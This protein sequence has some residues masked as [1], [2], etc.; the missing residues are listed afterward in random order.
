ML[1]ALAVSA[2]AASATPGVPTSGTTVYQETFGNGLGSSAGKVQTYSGN[3][4]ADNESYTA[5]PYWQAG[6]DCNG[7]IL[8]ATTT[9]PATDPCVASVTVGGGVVWSNLQAL[10][11][12]LG[13][14]DGL[15]AGNFAVSEYTGGAGTAGAELQTTS[16]N[17]PMTP[18]HFYDVSAWFG[19][20]AYAGAPPVGQAGCDYSDPSLTFSLLSPTLGAQAIGSNLD[21]CDAAGV[22]QYAGPNNVQFAVANLTS[23]AYRWPAA[24]GTTAGVEL[25]NANGAV[26]GN[27]HAFSD[28]MVT[29]VSPQISKSISPVNQFTDEPATLTFTVTNTY[30]PNGTLEAKDGWSF[31]DNMSAGLEVANLSDMTTDCPA[32][33]VSANPGATAIAVTGNL[34]AGQAYCTVSVNIIPASAAPASY[35]DGPAN[36][37]TNGLLGPPGNIPFDPVGDPHVAIVKHATVSPAA[38]QAAARLH[39]KIA[40]SYTVTNTGNEPMASVSVTDPTIGAVS[41]PA[42]PAGGLP[43]GASVTCTANSTHAVTAA[44]IENGQVTDTATAGGTDIYGET[45][46]TSAPYTAVVPTEQPGPSVAIHKLATVTPSADQGAAKVGDSIQYSYQVTN[47][48][49]VDLTSIS[50]HDASIGAVNCPVPVAPGLAPGDSETCTAVATHTVTQADVDAGSVTDTATASGVDAKGNRTPTSKPSTATVPTAAPEPS[51]SLQKIADAQN[52]D[53]T[54]ITLGETIQYSYYVTNTGNVSLSGIAVNDPT[55]GSVTCPQNTLAPGRGETCVEQTPY[56]VTQADVNNASA[57]DVATAGG[58]TPAGQ[59]VISNKSSTTVP[60]DPSPQVAVLKSGTVSPASDQNDLEVGDKIAYSYVVTNIGNVDLTTVAV[61]D[62]SIGAVTC[63]APAAPGLAPGA[64]ETCTANN[65]YTVNQVDVNAGIVTDTASA[66]GGDANGDHSPVSSQSKVSLLASPAAPL[67][68]IVKAAHVTP[69]ADQKHAHVGDRI[70]YTY[71]V[72]NIGNVDLTRIQVSDPTIGAVRC[73]RPQSP[74]LAPGKSE[75][76]TSARFHTVTSADVRRRMVSDVATSR[77]VDTRGQTS[78]ISKPSE[79]RVHVMRG[80]LELR[81]TASIRTVAAGQN[82]AYTLTVSNTTA[83]AITKVAVCDRLP[84]GLNYMSANPSARFERGAHC[85]TIPKL[86]GHASRAFTLIANVEP[87]GVART[88]VNHGTASA[89]GYRTAGASAAVSETETPPVINGS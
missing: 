83:A 81:K 85:W 32:A 59:S 82:V 75:T 80:G 42:L 78:A 76:C 9:M 30:S 60:S 6:T 64:S 50:V 61:S 68:S 72:K 38:D 39:D 79:A 44:D 74:G 35:T 62:A 19:A 56:T 86:G 22:K 5:S 55:G 66:T 34:N 26:G 17:I 53:Q 28:P 41:C 25:Y 63:P 88:L 36:M 2:D 13:T 16:D 84:P 18:G 20:V 89:T 14:A 27:D 58:T 65:P 31:T 69:R 40:Y 67:T 37:V 15:G 45:A 33:S 52:G 43:V 51:L 70:R 23:S 57:T 10:A 7:W 77:G 71:R 8:D 49:N 47:N 54:P 4:A 21:P 12:A 73:P 48:G 3:A 29:D 87:T 46:P 24:A 11:A 1:V